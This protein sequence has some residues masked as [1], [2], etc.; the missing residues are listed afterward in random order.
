LQCLSG[1]VT[2]DDE[3]RE[4]Y[5]WCLRFCGAHR[6]ICQRDARGY[7]EAEEKAEEKKETTV[8]DL[9]RKN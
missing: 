8:E 6:E 5:F 9:R 4:E 2:N 3:E 1:C 7:W